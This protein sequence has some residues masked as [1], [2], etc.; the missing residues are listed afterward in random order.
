[1]VAP[2]AVLPELAAHIAACP[3]GWHNGRTLI[4]RA[5]TDADVV[6][7]LQRLF[8]LGRALASGARGDAAAVAADRSSR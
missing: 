2:R 4:R 6:F 1:V 7:W 3:I 5:T 8:E